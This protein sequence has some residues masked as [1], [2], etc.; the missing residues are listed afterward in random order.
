MAGDPRWGAP[1]GLQARSEV[2]I[3]L[4]LA[5]L[6]PLARGALRAACLMHERPWRNF[7]ARDRAPPLIRAL[8]GRLR[9]LRTPAPSSRTPTTRQGIQA[10]MASL[11]EALQ[12]A[13]ACLDAGQPR[14]ALQ[15]C[16]AAL[17]ADKQSVEAFL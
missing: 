9:R 10:R 11:Q 4:A 5:Q 2:P 14:E 8:S 15:H 1:D 17:K 16:K 12:A 7:E 13:Q 3:S 6:C